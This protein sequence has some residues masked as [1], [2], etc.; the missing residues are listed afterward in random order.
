M[1]DSDHVT[2]L[3]RA[4]PGLVFDD[5]AFAL[6]RLHDFGCNVRVET[7]CDPVKHGPQPSI[8][9]VVTNPGMSATEPV[10]ARVDRA[11][12]LAVSFT[13]RLVAWLQEKGLD[14]LLHDLW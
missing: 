5:H 6:Q 4:I 7:Q 12:V 13:K 3:Y 10:F 9:P 2:H 14:L 11:K 1:H 8:H